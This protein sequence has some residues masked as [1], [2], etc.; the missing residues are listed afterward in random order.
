M[1]YCGK[2]IHLDVCKTADSCDGHVPQCK[3]F[4][5]KTSI[6]KRERVY[7]AAREAFGDECQLV[8]ALEELSEAQKEICK[9]L[10]GD[11]NVQHLA[12]E[13]ADATIVLEQV[14]QMFDLSAEVCRIMDEKVD[15]LA[16][17]IRE[18]RMEGAT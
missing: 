18:A 8:I 17:R 13:V 15:R 7:A 12:E 2:C 14:R 11:G 1:A 5:D 16:V 6:R 4:M 3:H 9:V 10:R